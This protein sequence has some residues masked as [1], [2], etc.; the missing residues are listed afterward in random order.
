[1]AKQDIDIGVEGNDSTG[2]S[3]RESFRKTNENFNEL[4]AVFGA[5]GQISFTNLGDTPSSLVPRQ[6]LIVNDAG[7]SIDYAE[8]ASN[9]AADPLVDDSITIS[10][11]VAGK[12]ILSTSFRA[13]S[14]DSSPSLG[15]PLDAR[16]GTQSNP[17]SIALGPYSIT[18]EAV[19]EFNR[20]HQS[21][22]NID[23]L[24]INKRFADERY[25]AGSLPIRVSDEPSNADSYTL[26]IDSY[27]QGDITVLSREDK[28]G[29]L[30]TGHGYDN[31][32]NG[33]PFKFFADDI[34]PSG[35]VSG[36]TYFL[37]Y[38]GQFTLSVH[39]TK[40]D[41]LVTSNSQAEAN[42][43]NVIGIIAVDDEHKFVDAAYDETLDGFFLDNEAIPRKAA[44]RRQGDVMTGPLVLHDSPGDLTGLATTRE[45]LQAA[46]KFYVDNT[47]YSSPTN[48][49]VSTSGDDTMKGVPA[50]KEG[51]SWSYAFK[52]INKA[53]QRADEIIRGSEKEPGPYMQTIT[54]DEG[55]EAATV[56]NLGTGVNN[57]LFANTRLLMDANKEFVTKEVTGYLKFKYPNFDYNVKTCERDTRLIIDSIALDIQKSPSTVDVTA[58]SLTRRAAER[59][60]GSVSGRTAIT[61]QLTETVDAIELARDLYQAILQNKLFKEAAITSISRSAIATVVTSVNHGLQNKNIVIIKEVLGMTEVNDNFYYAKITGARSFELYQDEDLITPVDSSS[62]GVYSSGGIIGLVYQTDEK[63]EFTVSDAEALARQGATDKFNLVTNIIQNGIDAGANIE[64]GRTY[65]IRITNGGG[66]FADQGDP[67]NRDISP[68]KIVVGKISGAQGRVVNYNS[69]K[70]TS[71]GDYD[72]IEVNLIKPIDFEPGEDLEYG[73]FVNKAQVTLM[74]E[75]GQYEEDY[76]IRLSANVTIS[77]DEFRRTIIRPKDRVSQ[78]P[79]ARTWF[80]RDRDFDDIPL[81]DSGARFYNQTGEFQGHFGY[82]YLVDPEKQLDIGI[83]VNNAGGYSIAANILQE[84]RTFIRNEVVAYINNNYK[85]LLFDKS[86]YADDLEAIIEDLAYGM[87]LDT[88]WYAVTNGLKFKRKGSIY[89]DD[90]LQE[91]WAVGL[92]EAKRVVAG[93][94]AVASSP[95]ATLRLN[96][97]F[98]EVIDIIENGTFETH[99]AA[100]TITFPAT[101]N[102][103][104]GREDAAARINNNRE[105]IAQEAYAW[106]TFNYPRKYFN[107]SIRLRDYRE[108]ADALTHDLTYE[109]NYAVQNWIRGI[110]INDV[111]RLEIT[112]EK[113]SADL[114]DHLSNVIENLLLNN[115][116]I[117][118][119][120]NSETPDLSGSNATST[121]VA[122]VDVY[123]INIIKDALLRNNT[124]NL[125]GT[126]FPNI[127]GLDSILIDAKSNID[128]NSSAVAAGTITNIDAVSVFSYNQ[129]KCSRDVGLIIDAMSQDLLDGGDEFSTEVQGEYY[130]GYISQYNNDGF[131][132]QENVTKRAIEYI[133][134]ISNR[135]FLGAYNPSDIEQDDTDADYVA[136]DFQFGTA[137]VGAS[138]IVVGLV[139]KIVYAFDPDY[140][141][142]KRN[143]EMDV[144]LCND[145]VRVEQVTVQGHGGFMMV[146]DPDGQILTKSPYIQ[147]GSSFSKSIDAKIF[148]G[149]MFV[150][151]YTGNLP[152]YIP[153]TIDPFGDGAVSGKVNNF[154]IWVQ[155]EPGTGL[156]IRPPQLPCPFFIEGRR[157]QVNGIANYNQANGWAR[158]IL[159]PASNGG[160][161]YD[162]TQFAEL[163]GQISRELYL[164]TAGN[165]SMLGND[166]T[167]INDLGYGLVVTNGALSEMVAMFTYYC[168]VAY[169]AKNGSEIRST[170][171]SNGY[172]NFGL[173]A[174]G[175]DP[176]EIPDQVTYEGD[177]TFPAKSI[178]FLTGG[179]DTNL[180]ESAILYV[181]DMKLRPQPN[182]IIVI[183][184]GGST[185]VLRYRIGAVSIDDSTTGSNTVYDDTVYRLAIQGTPEGENGDFFGNLQETVPD[186]TFIEFRNSETHQFDGVRSQADLQTRPSTAV[187]F[188]ESDDTTYRSISF[189]TANSF[190]EDIPDDQIITTFDI[191]FDFLELPVDFARVIA[192][193]GANPG[194]TI[195]PIRID[196]LNEQG[197]TIDPGE[198]IRLT[199]D[200]AGRQPGEV[201]YTG[202]MIFAYQGRTH[203][204]ADLQFDTTDIDAANLRPGVTYEITNVGDTD[205]DA[206]IGNTGTPGTY[207]IG[208]EIT[209]KTAGVGTGTAIDLG[210]MDLTI[211]SNPV[212]DITSGGTGISA[213][214][215]EDR[216]LYA[217]VPDTTTAEITVRI[218]LCRATSHDFTQIG[219]GSFNQA[220]YPNQLFGA[221]EGNRQAEFYSDATN[222]TAA[223]VWERRKGR[224]FWMST[225]QNGFFRVGKFFSVDQGQGSIAFSGEIG[226]T[227]ANQ[228]GF[229]LGVPVNEFSVDD[230]M[231]DESDSAVPVE[232]AIVGYIN[233]RLGRDKNDTNVT[234]RIGPGFLS[235]SGNSVM[236][237]QLQMG[238]SK[239][240]NVATPT[241]AKDAATKGYVDDKI[242]EFDNYESLRNTESNR[243]EGNDIVVY[244]GLYK[245][246]TTIPAT[247]PPSGTT[248][249]V[250]DPIEDVSGDK[251][252]IVRD[253]EIV[254]DSIIG[255]GQPSNNIAIITYELT[256]GSAN[257]NENE[258]IEGTGAKSTVSANI[259]RGPFDEIA[260]SRQSDDSVIS[261]TVSRNKSVAAQSLTD[262]VSEIDLQIINDSIVN[263][264]INSNASIQQS[265]LLM[266][267][268]EPIGSSAGLFGTGDDTGQGSRGLAAF[269]NEEFS[270]DYQLIVTGGFVTAD[271]GD[272]I[273]VGGNRGYLVTDYINASTVVVRTGTGFTVGPTAISI[274]TVDADGVEQ[275]PVVKTGVTITSALPSGFISNLDRGISL[276]KLQELPTDHVIGRQSDDT[277]IAQAVSFE[278]VVDQGFALQDVDFE[279]SEIVE[280]SGQRITFNTLVNVT[281]GETFEQNQ[282]GGLIV[283]GTVQGKVQSEDTVTV[284][285][286][287]GTFN[288][289]PITASITGPMP[290]VLAVSPSNALQGAALIRQADGIYGTTQV[291]T[292][293]ATNSM[294]RRD[295]DGRL[296]ASAYVIGGSS[297]QEILAEA[298]GVLTMKT[299]S[300]GTILISSGGNSS[301]PAFVNM[302]GSVNVGDTGVTGQGNAQAAVVGLS[303]DGFIASPWNYTNFIEAIDTKNSSNTTGIG[304]GAPATFNSSLAGT[305]V[306]VNNGTETGSLNDS[307]LSLN[308]NLEINSDKFTVAEDT[309]NTLVAGTLAVGSN[310]TINTDKFSVTGASGNTTIAG[311]LAVTGTTSL[312][313]DVNLGNAGTDT[314]TVSGQ[315]DSNIVP[316]NTTHNLGSGTNFWNTVYATT[317]SGTATNARYADLAENYLADADYEPGTVLVLGG[318][319]EVT[320]TN[321]K[322]DTRVAGIIT[323]NPAHLMNSELEGEFIAGVALQGRVP[324]KVLG[325]V[326]KGDILV[327]SAIPGHAIVD[328]NPKIGSIIGKAVGDKLD[329]GKGIVEVLVGKS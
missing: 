199:R 65:N 190:G 153:E 114:M 242:T 196:D 211:E 292:A 265:K 209:C 239:V 128:L 100:D 246:Y 268:A 305:I 185:G 155:S 139:A 205:W 289:A 3:I 272:V 168:Q 29:N 308:T 101:A 228:L 111:T 225:D 187:N 296:Q 141:P 147:I 43:I 181:T 150:D 120:G 4:Y 137:E 93:L 320:I 108:L 154:E 208:D 64:E 257:F 15:A 310:F 258:D 148:A 145:A 40:E 182:S 219:A 248:L 167:Q 74:V 252:G 210:A 124:T 178:T 20:V 281:D 203:Q 19:N 68:G 86:Q 142:P 220:N 8:L 140:N 131:G 30:L 313:G 295:A 256:N 135:L 177:M 250:D 214:F 85:D 50:G 95:V 103:P 312:N 307:T 259:I 59:Y 201:G 325:V 47:S 251:T 263:A 26:I 321:T 71:G 16:G 270:Q 73:N 266:E 284:V 316:N 21:D 143:D 25:I 254:S 204:V 290:T 46:T 309:G 34:D 191:G 299:P 285:S 249:V 156:F 215:T 90:Y 234:G 298:S 7:T 102:T 52:S 194:D 80:Y 112:T 38:T 241:N 326:K 44:V 106:L 230:T 192:G 314:V 302:P 236:E 55:A 110:F 62:F 217:G 315:V 186:G 31:A 311:T 317:F 76:P 264:D 238:N 303:G 133:N 170:T 161:G 329:D 49:Y 14:Q 116:I 91:L 271:A 152:V 78:S 123:L 297:T 22:I 99:D 54:V 69:E 304:F 28:E 98:D 37:R 105:F 5:G 300:Q 126:V 32:I 260:H 67:T 138:N 159:D 287:S 130:R 58:N 72:I 273:I 53:A 232:K 13:L 294:A 24:V 109:G 206:V 157:F 245:A 70:E 158:L 10:Y 280:L 163:N 306:F 56:I 160:D 212:T 253:I 136:P 319:Q 48:I 301:N 118:T 119:E 166:F 282:G 327:T 286:T 240:T 42:K 96:S 293:S 198:R 243:P 36:E 197:L 223:Q 323:T 132:G 151:A 9:S 277:G 183:D 189:G 175:A 165:R 83:S 45:D 1:M 222:A 104:T 97:A 261:I 81:A 328:N 184:H 237:G 235:L 87:V 288:T 60:Y 134:D 79:F 171:G 233:K 291:S 174:E 216:V 125:P 89:L 41:A 224:V 207:N 275:T 226:I 173:V 231:A 169:Y 213:A 262:P 113:V 244:T 255:E 324:C 227:G 115:P 200:V 247:S 221:P 188:D 274:A 51:T 179:E 11:D 18:T 107:E 278:D 176:N 195:I 57:P 129:D 66:E 218:S 172:G 193:K 2:D 17:F 63:Q 146:L 12:I 117:P 144:F 164:Q 121:E 149:G 61:R 92:R 229:K 39:R 267:R 88:N 84:N 122:I 27:S 180:A 75:S 127:T 33:T 94:P 269:E 82:H 283:T 162:E 35:L 77:G 202:G 279:E 322:G 318:E 276:S 6:M 23:D